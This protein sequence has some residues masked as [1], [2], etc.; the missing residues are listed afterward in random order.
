VYLIIVYDVDV[1]RVSKVNS[2]LKRYLVWVQNSVFE[3]GLSPGQYTEMKTGLSEIISGNDQVR[4]Y[5]LNSKK[6]FSLET[7]PEKIP[8]PTERFL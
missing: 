1:S 5:K 2:F 3:G 8:E 7:I 4:I 6:L